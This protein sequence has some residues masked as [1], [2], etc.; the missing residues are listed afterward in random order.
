MIHLIPSVKHQEIR[1]GILGKKAINYKKTGYDERIL[2]ALE[3]LPYDDDGAR[4]DI[5]IEDGSG[6]GYELQIDKDNILVKANGSA[7]A[8]YAIQTLRQIFKNDKVPCM[9]IQDEPDF[10]YR[11]FYHDV[12]RGKV[13]TVDTLKHL[14]DEMAYYKLNSLQLYVEHTFE[15]EETKEI[16]KKTGCLSK[17][18]IL[19]L[20]R[21][22]HNNFIE[23]I[24]SLSTFGHLYEL[25]EQE[26]YQHL[27][28]VKEFEKKCN[29]WRARMEHHTIDPLNPESI[30]IIK[31]LID[32]YEPLFKSKYF[33]ICCDETFDLKQYPAECMDEA[34]LYIDF[35]KQIIEHV[36]RKSKK[37]MMWADIL[38]EHP[39]TIE[40]LADDICFLNWNY[41]AEP[42]EEKIVQ[43]AKKGRKQI[44]CPGTTTWNRFC[45]N[46]AVEES[47]IS[48]MAEYGY[49]H[50][51]IGMLNTNW[52]D[53]GNPCSIELAMYGLVL[54]AAKSWNVQ[55]KLGEE[56][57]ESV[58]TLLYGKANAMQCLKEM[59]EMHQN[60]SWVYFCK[61]YFSRRYG[62]ATNMKPWDIAKLKKVQDTYLDLK[63]ILETDIWDMDEYRQEMSLA[64]EGICVMAE[65][66]A[67]LEGMKV[68]RITDTEEW[69][70]KYRAKW[71]Q[72]NKES[73]LCNIEEMFRYCETQ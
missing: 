5:E 34:R 60:I 64:A 12:T 54:G 4:L 55:M 73:E 32:Q 1:N 39:E 58:N 7:G 28:V 3:K 63:S 40:E 66:Y 47:N 26:P 15:F 70:R 33:N 45:E 11:G 37:V 30:E 68:K 62:K 69:I 43:L 9:F 13:P 21:H 59:S 2:L 8:F 35:V 38:L 50:G 41:D 16:I 72:K 10:E 19:E 56:F 22:C 48:L 67:K 61:K 46:V 57:Y 27:R 53:W 44:V 36:Q 17:E 71:M 65:L 20:E 42:S 52:G 6:E 23:F 18:E 31:S 14:I 49:K 51:A 29:F 24:P 25:L